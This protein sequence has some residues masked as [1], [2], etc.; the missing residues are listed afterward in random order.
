MSFLLFNLGL[1]DWRRT[2]LVYHALAELGI[3][4][5][6]IQRTEQEYFCLGH[7]SSIS[8]LNLEYLRRNGIPVFRR[9]IGGGL[10]FLDREQVFYH[11]VVQRDSPLCPVRNEEFFRRFLNPVVRVYRSYGVEAEYKPASDIVAYGKKVSG[12]G[13]G[14]IGDCKVL[15]G[16]VLLDF[17]AERFVSALNL[18]SSWFREQALKLVSSKVAGLRSFGVSTTPEEVEARL[19]GEFERLVGR[20]KPS[21]ITPEIEA[22][23]ERLA[24]ERFTE[25]WLHQDFDSSLWRE[26]KVAEGCFIFEYSQGNLVVRGRRGNTI[27]E[28]AIYVNGRRM[29]EL[30]KELRDW[31][32]LKEWVEENQRKVRRG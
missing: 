15:S 22:E 7:F 13:A 17:N 18:P 16:S 19:I 8:E 12:N 29:P 4:A 27:E 23:M 1:Q 6:V 14:I 31:E 10:V 3:E 24:E 28:L 25:E 26:L 32:K 30:E 9:E 21:R 2:Q 11:L 20:L 5:V